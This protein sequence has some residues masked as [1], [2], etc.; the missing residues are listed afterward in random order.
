M[1]DE[2]KQPSWWITHNWYLYSGA[3]AVVLVILLGI[4]IAFRESPLEIDAEWMEEIVENRHP[5]GEFL[6]LVF[7]FIGGYWFGGALVPLA[8][9]AALLL[10]R[11]RWGA[12]YF[13]LASLAS[14][15]V[16]Q[17]LKMAFSRARPE[18]ILIMID[19]GSFPSGHVANAAT[20]SVALAIIF[21]KRWLWVLAF[22][23]TV[24]MAISRT[25]LGAHWVSDTIGAVI[26][27]VAMAVIVWAPFA[28]H[29]SLERE[30]RLRAAGYVV[31]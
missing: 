14:F 1:Q 27:G 8:I 4:V 3:A 9:V 25:Y 22:V 23:Y 28:H 17:A 13:A 10:A 7:D 18:E 2:T 12:L 19:T 20:V 31:I 24:L 29:L 11:R 30:R 21:Q 26:V 16:V 5:A 6:A 15:L